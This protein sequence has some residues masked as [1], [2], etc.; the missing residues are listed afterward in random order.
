MSFALMCCVLTIGAAQNEL[1]TGWISVTSQSGGFT[2][3]MPGMP[4]EKKQKVETAKGHLNVF[5]LVAEG[6][7]SSLYAVSYSD[8]PEAE[9]KKDVNER[10]LDQARDSAVSAVRG[11]LRTEK[12]LELAGHPGRDIVIENDGAAIARMRIVLVRRRLYQVMA[13]GN[14]AFLSGKDVGVFLDSFRL[15]K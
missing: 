5:L 14:A 6:G 12:A 13:L 3:A 8:L 9:L 4:T 11:K 10:R 1:P 2:V 15:N 7:D